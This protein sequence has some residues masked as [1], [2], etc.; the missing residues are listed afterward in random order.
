MTDIAVPSDEIL[1]QY[2]SGSLDV[3]VRMLVDAHLERGP[4]TRGALASFERLSGALLA[5]SPP[6]R[7]RPD[8][9]DRTFAAI[10]RGDWDDGAS[11]GL[12][13]PSPTLAHGAWRWAGPGARVARVAAPGARAK[14]FLMRIARGR[15]MPE[16]GHLGREYTVVLQG[17]Y[18]Y[19]SGLVSQ[20]AFVE[21]GPEERHQPIVSDDGDCVCL[22][23]LEAPI[24]A[25]GLAGLGARWAMR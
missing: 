14:I 20:G 22:F 9:L 24:A 3:G 18:R 6:A 12:A 4:S 23:A 13:E 5:T 10:D 21:A 7:L 2:A 1:L 15:A 11:T 19:E 17:A 25:R 16:H 8:A